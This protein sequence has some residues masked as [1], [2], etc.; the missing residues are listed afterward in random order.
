MKILYFSLL[1][2]FSSIYSNAQTFKKGETWAGSYQCGGNN[3]EFKLSI[4]EI[5]NDI[6]RSKFIFLN[7]DGVFEMIGKYSNNEFTF[8][9]TNW[10]QNPDQGYVTIGLHGFYLSSPDRLIGNTISKLTYTEGKECTGF[11]LEREK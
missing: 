10:L 7:G 1:L 8:T 6:V 9:G 3:L 4:E 5:Q 2:V 11:F